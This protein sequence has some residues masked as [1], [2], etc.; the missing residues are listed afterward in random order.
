MGCEKKANDL[1]FNVNFAC[2][3]DKAATETL[4]L[5][6]IE[7][8]CGGSTRVYEASLSPG[9]EAPAGKGIDPGQ[10]G[11]EAIA[12]SGGEVLASGCVEAGLPAS[13]PPTIELRSDTCTEGPDEDAGD[14]A[15]MDAGEDA[16]MDASDDGGAD[17]AEPALDTGADAAL[18]PDAEAG[19][20]DASGV[21]DAAGDADLADAQEAD[22][23]PIPCSTDCKDSFPCTEDRCVNGECVHEP[24]TGT[25]E[26]DGVACTQNDRCESGNCMAGTPNNAACPDDGNPC[27]AEICRVSGGCSRQ[28]ASNT[29]SCNDNIGCTGPDRCN[30][31]TCRGA[32]MC[33]A[34]AVCSAATGACRMCSNN[35]DCNDNDPCT[36]DECKNGTCN[37]TRNVGATG[38]C[39]D[40]K[41][42][43]NN[44]ACTATGCAGT[45]TCPNDASCSD[46]STCDCGDDDEV[47]CGNSCVDL[48]SDA[49]NCGQCGRSCGSNNSC[50]NRACKPAGATCTAWRY[51]GH[52]YLVCSDAQSWT[53]ARDKCRGWGLGLAIVDN[54]E[55]NDF[56]RD[57]SEGA[58]HW[59]AANDR[60]DNGGIFFGDSE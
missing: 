47:L 28:N 7:G 34:P 5:H 51:N 2:P 22:A 8:G 15:G 6:V 60:G 31:G 52:D 29:T 1:S 26:C 20:P 9:D 11:F 38:V 37:R 4:E 24:H 21:A 35:N 17:G 18:D 10:Y 58:K 57:K 49:A 23:A 45:S 3:E 39:T 48:D 32:D 44:D 55:E 30:N 19:D 25:R 42:C 53:A 12:Y 40:N 43:T 36:T 14:D 16:A 50:Q 13:E 56:L 46:E 41:S 54:V 59:I 27:T 33:T